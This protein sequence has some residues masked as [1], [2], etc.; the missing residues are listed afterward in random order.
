M[1]TGTE[2]QAIGNLTIGHNPPDNTPAASQPITGDEI[3]IGQPT[4]QFCA[5]WTKQ[6]YTEEQAIERFQALESARRKGKKRLPG[7]WRPTPA[8]KQPTPAQPTPAAEKKAP[9]E[10]NHADFVLSSE[11]LST[12]H[13]ETFE[14]ESEEK[15]YRIPTSED[16][17]KG[18]LILGRSGSSTME[19]YW[20][21]CP[22]FSF[23]KMLI[24]Q[25]AGRANIVLEDVESH[26]LTV[27][28]A[29]IL[30]HFTRV[31]G[32]EQKPSMVMDLFVLVA[33]SY[34][35]WKAKKD[36]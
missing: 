13:Q 28:A 5:Y 16:E 17:A 35:I 24:H 10:S 19:N 34:G 1:E 12:S 31:E 21:H 22:D 23:V 25:L 3:P 30:H 32:A 14:L 2:D 6:G 29:P 4:R 27:C 7:D 33:T 20:E 36:A 26:T 15:E 8:A 11:P 18:M 9:L